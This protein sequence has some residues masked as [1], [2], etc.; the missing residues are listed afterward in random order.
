MR[1]FCAVVCASVM[2]GSCGNPAEDAVR[3]ELIDGE[4]ARFRDVA[5][6]SGDSEIWRGDV[7]GKNRMGAYTGFEP[8]FYD[9]IAVAFLSSDNF[10]DMMGRCYS[11]L[12]AMAADVKDAAED[13]EAEM[14]GNTTNGKWVI[15]SSTNPLDDSKTSTAT[16]A[17]DEGTSR[18]NG[19]VRFV[20]RCQSNQT[21][22]YVVWHEYLGDDS[23]SVYDEY[24]MV[25]VRVGDAESSSQQWGI[26][27]DKQA[28]FAPASIDLLR[29]M[30]KQK[31]LVMQT[32]PYNESPITA[33]FDLTGAKAAIG[34]VA[35]T[36]NWE[37]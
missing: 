2:L 8:F 20:A 32:T 34:E 12:D 11:N 35:K 37:L 16:L 25:D 27:T 28:T 26:S 24:K 36:C 9:G 1:Y 19:P 5:R 15:D 7:N 14:A 17:A 29:Q 22:V 21:E 30:A 6:C 23:R 4:S 13:A 3:A 18:F 31:R 10:S 33:V